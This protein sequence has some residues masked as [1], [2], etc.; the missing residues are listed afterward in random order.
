MAESF[1]EMAE[2]LAEQMQRMQRAQQMTMVGQMA[3][4][5]VHEIKNPL[6]GIKGSMQLLLE[7]G[8]MPEESRMILSKTMDEV[9]RIESLMKNLLNFAKPPQLLL[10]PADMNEVLE[11][12]L[13]VSLPYSSLAMR[14]PN[15][16]GVTKNFDPHLPLT[17]VD[18]IQMQQVFLNLLMNAVE[19]MPGG[20]TLSVRTSVNGLVPGIQIEIADT[21]KG[22]DEGIREKIFEP[23]FTTKH[24]GTGLG[25]AISK[26]FVEMHGGTISVEK[27][28]DGGTTF[29]IAL[30]AAF[31]EAAPVPDQSLT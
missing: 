1:N 21:G 15:A 23:F 6:A 12:T 3:A 22:I 13:T 20:G 16:I 29:R 25:L 28:P 5:L 31:G 24:K 14:S 10:V 7:E 9:Q 4:G 30:P 27:N 19:A 18:P 17:M 2:S 26:Q 8:G 11:S